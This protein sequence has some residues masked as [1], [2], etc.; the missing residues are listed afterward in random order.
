METVHQHDPINPNEFFR[1]NS[2]LPK[3]FTRNPFKPK[4][5]AAATRQGQ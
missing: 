1:S 4:D 5:L 2:L 3:D